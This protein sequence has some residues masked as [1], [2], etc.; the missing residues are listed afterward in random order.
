MMWKH[1]RLRFYMLNASWN[2]KFWLYAEKIYRNHSYD[3]IEEGLDFDDVDITGKIHFKEKKVNTRR[4]VGYK[5]KNGM[6]LDNP[7]LRHT[8]DKETWN[9]WK[10]KGLIKF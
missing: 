3:V 1:S 6:Y 4:F 5:Y 8:V 10:K 2:Y 9:A 7:G